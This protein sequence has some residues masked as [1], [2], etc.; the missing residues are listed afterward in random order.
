MLDLSLAVLVE[1]G[2][3]TLNHG[4]QGKGSCQDDEEQSN[5]KLGET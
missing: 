4:G 5:C 1:R 3:R 2:E